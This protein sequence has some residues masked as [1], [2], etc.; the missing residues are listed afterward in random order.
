MPQTNDETA[1][2]VAAAGGHL[3]VV[4]ALIAAGADVNARSIPVRPSVLCP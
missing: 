2:T 4:E 1:L 3:S